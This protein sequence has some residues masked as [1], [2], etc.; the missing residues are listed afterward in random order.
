[1]K[2]HRV[3][4]FLVLTAQVNADMKVGELA[5]TITVSEAYAS[6]IPGATY[7]NPTFRDVGG[8][9][10]RFESQSRSHLCSFRTPRRPP[11][12]HSCPFV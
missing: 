9:V 7:T 10:G 3:A 12:V 11:N 6:I 5:E 4:S 8:N 2:S 1:M